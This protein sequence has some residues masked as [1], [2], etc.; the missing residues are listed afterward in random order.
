MGV[1]GGLTEIKK[2]WWYL[3]NF[4]WKRGKWVSNDRY[5]DEDLVAYG[6]NRKLHSLKRLCHTEAAEMLDLWMTPSGN[7]TKLLNSLKMKAIAP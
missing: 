6:A 4:V 1:T 3:V 7:H 2:S 5:M